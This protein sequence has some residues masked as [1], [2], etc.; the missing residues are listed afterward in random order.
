MC[1]GELVV[2]ASREPA[3]Q[4]CGQCGWVQYR[5]PSPGVTVLVVEGDQVLLG[6]RGPESFEP[7]K[8]CLPGGFMEFEE[9]FLAAGAREVL[10][11]TGLRVQIRSIVN[12]VTNFLAPNLHTLVV[13]LLAQV[14]G[15]EATPGDDVC[16][17]GWYP[18]SGPLP[19]MAF[20]A[21]EYIVE[22]CASGRLEELRVQPAPGTSD[23]GIETTRPDV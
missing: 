22:R 6:K 15:G 4:R 18:L 12:V 20:E 3:R 2:D 5:N 17:L 8:W 14:V 16:E 10:E 1:A 11:E 23:A 19:E 9:D 21:D 7:D 13:V